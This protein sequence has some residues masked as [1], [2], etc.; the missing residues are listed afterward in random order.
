MFI[1]SEMQ[2]LTIL[3]DAKD[4]SSFSDTDAVRVQLVKELLA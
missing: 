2:R 4:D 3:L 1:M